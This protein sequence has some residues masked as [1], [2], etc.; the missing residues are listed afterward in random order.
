MK[1]S[2]KFA[3]LTGAVV[4]ATAIAAHVMKKKA[5][6]TTYEADLIEP[7]EKRK[8]GFYEKYGKRILDIACATAAIVVFSPLY[9]DVAALV[10]LKLG[11]PVLFTQDRPGLI[12]KDGK[13][14]VFKM[15]KFRTMTDE[16]DENGELLPD[17]VRLTKFGKW[18]RNTSLDELPE[19][20]NILN[21]T[22][23]VIGPRP[24]LVR[25]MTF[26]TKEQRAR[27]T[28]KPGLSGLAQVNG[29]NG[30]SWEEK[31][32]WDRKYI[33]N[34]SFAGDVKIIVDTVKKA[35]IKQEGIT[36]EDMAT[37][38]DFG[39]W[40]LRTEKVAEVEYEAKQ[41]QAKSI[42]N[43][44]E[45]LESEN[46]K[47]VL[48][49][50]SVVSFIEWFNKENLEYLK[51]NLN[52]EV[53][54]ACN[55][56]YMDDTDETRT[57]EYIAKLKKEGF[58]LHNIHL[59]L[60]INWKYSDFSLYKDIFGFSIWVTISSLAQR[61]VFNITPSILGTVASSAAIALFGIVATI[62][63]YTYTITT[64]I[65]GMFMPKISRIYE[66]GGEKDELMPLMLS[67]GKFQYAIN[68]LIVAGFAVVGKEFINLWMGPTYLDAYYGILLVIIP[69]LFFNS[70][71]IANTAMIVRKKVNLQAWVNLGMGMVSVLLSIILSSYFG[72]IGA[73]ISISIAYMLRAVVL[74]FI[75]KRVLKIDMASFVVNCYFRMGIPII[76][77]IMLRF[78]MN[79]LLP[80][81]G[82]LVLAAKG[83]V[84]VG[85]YAVVTLL[86]GLNSEERNKLLR[87]KV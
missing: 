44:S 29:R 47:K 75:Y 27:H 83:V 69:G 21:G 66:R 81:G 4:G 78:L 41:K 43:G 7:I 2:K 37:A 46:I 45:T 15:Y 60:K 59:T 56:D 53:H 86:L 61:L 48:V 34:V 55:F 51:N 22:M 58:I 3:L 49:V 54:V 73:C 87:R 63:G 76:I 65:N 33:Q 23:S 84:I 11:S 79:S 74:L 5:E 77:T 35:F 71:Q 16:R 68:G 8:M 9:L 38:E 25:D 31:L 70:M 72:V 10:K 18:L 57:R 14:T 30:I 50:A 6:K 82:W 52:C 26:M 64:A 32:E 24:Q 13:E 39:D 67:V 36:Q 80:N 17:D 42:L 28:A 40:L 12:G 85:I 62:E 19:A 1:K 20:F